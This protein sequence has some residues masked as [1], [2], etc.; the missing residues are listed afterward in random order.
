MRKRIISE[1]QLRKTLRRIIKE[2]ASEKM[3]A[4]DIER[5]IETPQFERTVDELLMNLSKHDIEELKDV[6][7]DLG[8]TPESSVIDIHDKIEDEEESP[9]SFTEMG[10]DEEKNDDKKNIKKKTANIL[11]SLGAGNIA[12]WGG[13]PLA[14]AIGSATGMPVG[15]AI[16]WG[17]SGLMLALAKALQKK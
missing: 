15:F 9:M 8:I 6:I 16:S 4:K 11:H 10:E 17:V 5:K 12:A 13:V 14:I 3:M 7:S 1:S 2:N